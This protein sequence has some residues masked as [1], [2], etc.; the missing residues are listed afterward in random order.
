MLIGLAAVLIGAVWFSSKSLQFPQPSDTEGDSD[1]IS[2]LEEDIRYRESLPNSPSPNQANV[3]QASASDDVII[4]TVQKNETLS[5]ISKRYYGSI[6][7]VSLIIE[8]NKIENPQQIR[9]GMR[10]KIPPKP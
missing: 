2:L 8:N 6:Q 3:N 7:Y 10:L 5:G 4:H 1:K 9:P